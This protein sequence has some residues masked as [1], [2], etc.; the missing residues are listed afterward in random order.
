MSSE[1]YRRHR[2]VTSIIPPHNDTHDDELADPLSFSEQLIDM[3]S[4]KKLF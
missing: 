3:N 1:L 2:H 4:H